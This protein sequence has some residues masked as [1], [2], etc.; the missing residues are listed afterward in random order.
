M[1]LRNLN[2]FIRHFVAF[3]LPFYILLFLNNEVNGRIAPQLTRTNL[4][5]MGIS[6]ALGLFVAIV[7]RLPERVT[8]G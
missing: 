8:L 2:A 5:V 4:E 7:F 1:F 6:I 3:S